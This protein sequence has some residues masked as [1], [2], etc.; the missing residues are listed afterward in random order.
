[1]PTAPMT[2][3]EPR[4][5]PR[6]AT[7]AELDAIHQV[8]RSAYA[9]YADRM[10]RPPGPVLTDYGPAVAAGDVWV[11]GRPPVG[12]LCLVSKQ[13]SLLIENVAVEPASQ[14]AG[15]GRLL[16]AF[17]EAHALERGQ[18]RLTL[19]THE[20]MTENLALYTWLGYQETHRQTTDGY[21]RVFM[22]KQL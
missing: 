20:V 12:V 5:Q 9:K 16:L 22:E 6:P 19:Y 17:A 1:M 15:I 13:D 21:H 14:G 3:S 4:E 8:I 18:I 2:D 7:L 10:A 11:V